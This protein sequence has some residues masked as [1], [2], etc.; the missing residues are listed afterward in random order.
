MN[1][2]LFF[3]IPVS[4]WSNQEV[5]AWLKS[6]NIVEIKED[7]ENITGVQ[8]LAISKVSIYFKDFLFRNRRFFIIEVSII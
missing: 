5:K 2:N 4:E 7:F 3:R 8:L 1:K 6:I